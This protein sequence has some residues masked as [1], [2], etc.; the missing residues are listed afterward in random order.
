MKNTQFTQFR[1]ED[2]FGDIISKYSILPEQITKPNNFCSQNNVSNNFCIKIS[3]F[4]P[5][6]KKKQ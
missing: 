3:L 5:E 2:V 4:K 6:M 1:E